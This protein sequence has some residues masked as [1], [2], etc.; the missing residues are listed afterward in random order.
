[1]KKSF[2]LLA[3]LILSVG[4]FSCSKGDEP[5]LVEDNSD[6]N[7]SKVKLQDFVGEWVYLLN[8]KEYR[9]IVIV[10]N[11]NGY[12]FTHYEKF[13]DDMK[14]DDTYPVQTITEDNF[15]STATTSGILYP[16]VKI[17]STYSSGQSYVQYK[18]FSKPLLELGVSSYYKQ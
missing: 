2:L 4:L 15:A 10:S 8:G 11:E 7:L 5:T 12:T 18:F 16:Y 9:K 13:G 6:K 3:L 1:M 17:K 14:L